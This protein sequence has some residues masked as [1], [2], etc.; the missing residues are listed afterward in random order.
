MRPA[1][2]ISAIAAAS[3]TTNAAA[4]WAAGASPSAIRAGIVIG[5]A[6]GRKEE[7]VASVP[8]GSCNTAK[9]RKN[10][11]HEDQRERRRD[12]LQLLLAGDQRAGARERGRVEHVADH[13]PAE[14]QRGG[15]DHVAVH[16]QRAR[17]GRDR[18]PQHRDQ[19]SWTNPRTPSPITLPA[20][21]WRGRIVASSTSTTREA[22]SST[23]PLATRNPS[24]I[25]WP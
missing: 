1:S 19:S 18:Q 9:E 3:V 2:G 15:D 23:T 21:S 20:S 22:F 4:I 25:S 5:A 12:R 11:D 8:S 14:R 13:E 6:G 17:R 10:D 16:L 24:P 7:T